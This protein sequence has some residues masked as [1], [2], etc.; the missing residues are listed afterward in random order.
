MLVGG[1]GQAEHVR[2]LADSL[3]VRDNWVRFLEEERAGSGL[4]QKADTPEKHLPNDT[5]FT[6]A[7]DKRA[8]QAPPDFV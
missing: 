2:L 3:P 1:L 5:R 8:E 7:E 6:L 4:R